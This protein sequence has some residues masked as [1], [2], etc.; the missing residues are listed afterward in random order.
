M[1]FFTAKIAIKSGFE[2]KEGWRG[3][4]SSFSRAILIF[5]PYLC[6]LTVNQGGE[7]DEVYIF[8]INLL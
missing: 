7:R 8:S 2:K 3:K 1:I 5:I 6:R 4:K